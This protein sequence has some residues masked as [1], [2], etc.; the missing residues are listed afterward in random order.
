MPCNATGQNEWQTAQSLPRNQLA[1]IAVAVCDTVGNLSTDFIHFLPDDIYVD[2][3]DPGFIEERGNWSTS[4]ISS[5]GLD[6]RMAILAETDTAKVKWIADIRQSGYYNVFV[7]VP[8]VENAAEQI[9]FKIYNNSECADTTIFTHS[10][11]TM[12]WVYIG[13]AF[14]TVQE[15]NYL[16]MDAYGNEQSGKVVAADVAKFSALVRERDLYVEPNFIDLGEVSQDDTVSFNLKVTNC[17]LEDLTLFGLSFATQTLSTR[18]NFPIVIAGMSYN[19]LPMQFHSPHI[20]IVSDTL[21]ITS[22]DPVEPNYSVPL[23]ANVQ[24]FF[25]IIDNE[26][27][28]YYK[29][30]G[31]WHYSN[32]QAYGPTSRYSF[33]SK[34]PGANASFRSTLN[35]SGVYEIFEIVPSTVNATNHAVYVL[36]IS[37]VVVDSV[38]IDQNQGSGS[39]VSLGRYYLPAGLPIE[40]KVVD[41]GKSTAGD[42]LRADA[43]KFSLIQEISNINNYLAEN[44]PMEFQVEQNYPN[45]FNPTTTIQ[46]SLSKPGFVELKV[47]SSL[48]S[49]VTTLISKPM[50]AGRHEVTFDASNLASGVYYYR[51]SVNELI[52]TKRMLLVK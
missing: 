50:S 4:F 2:N 1:K 28:L 11:P 40:I 23:N 39:W 10:L 32:A 22:D 18:L 13:T 45:P 49:E 20:G 7:Q 16:E 36:S 47:F 26:D 19:I 12:D 30:E 41:T 25:V 15:E 44:I 52:L 24:S 48:G 43:I 51:L 37:N 17:G 9:I 8:A 6:S 5:W 29:E 35:R 38:I 14:L 21:F 31:T 46:F 34:G 27:S 3:I 42:V 33:L